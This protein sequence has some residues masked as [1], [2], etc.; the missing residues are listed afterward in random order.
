[1]IE[2][3][4]VA[5]ELDAQ[6][7][8]VLAARVNDERNGREQ[9]FAQQRAE[10]V[11]HRGGAAADERVP[12]ER[13]DGTRARRLRGGGGALPRNRVD[14][15]K[16]AR[17]CAGNAAIDCRRRCGPQGALEHDSTGASPRRAHPL[18]RDFARRRQRRGDGV[19]VVVGVGRRRRRGRRVHNQAREPGH[20]EEPVAR[21]RSEERVREHAAARA[22]EL[23]DD[24]VAVDAADD[25]D[26]P[27]DVHRVGHLVVRRPTPLALSSSS[28][29]TPRRR[30]KLPWYAEQPE[31]PRPAR[32]LRWFAEQ[33]AAEAQAA[34][35]QL[36]WFAA[37]QALPPAVGAA[38]DADDDDDDDDDE[39][40]SDSL[41]GLE[42]K[43]RAARAGATSGT[44]G[45]GARRATDQVS[46][47]AE[48]HQQATDAAESAAAAPGATFASVERAAKTARAA[49]M[50]T[51]A[52]QQV[53][54]AAAQSSSSASS[55]SSSSSSVAA[56]ATVV[57][58][59]V[60]SS[61]SVGAVFN[62]DGG[63]TPP[64]SAAENYEMLRQQIDTS[65]RQGHVPQGASRGGARVAEVASELFR[66]AR[67]TLSG[68]AKPA[69]V[70]STVSPLEHTF[71]QRV[72]TDTVAA[73]GLPPHLNDP[74]SELYA[75]LRASL[76]VS[77]RRHEEAM[78][79]P[80][81]VGE[82]ECARGASCV[83]N[84]IVSEGSGRTLV[85]FYYEDELAQYRYDLEHGVTGAR[86]PDKSRMCILC[87]RSDVNRWIMAARVQNV[88]YR[89]EN[90]LD[91][92]APVLVQQ[93]YNLVNVPGEYRIE[94]C[95]TP[96]A[97]VHEG[98]V[99]PVVKPNLLEIRRVVDPATG[100]VRFEQLLQYPSAVAPMRQQQQQQQ[101]VSAVS[102]PA[103]PPR[104][105]QRVSAV[106]AAA[107][108]SSSTTSSS[109]SSRADER[110]GF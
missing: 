36:P 106:S 99:Y 42:A 84:K 75:R 29:W 12:R 103:S 17:R 41:V 37:P 68:L 61:A 74:T 26:L 56:A 67:G 71:M 49:A 50:P 87:M 91:G 39:S 11:D 70:P 82:H 100:E 77:H 28:A 23:D 86:L 34:P 79:R 18:S 13:D 60:L 98:L 9:Q 20:H 30:R 76:R 38:A 21:G 69:I 52:R 19:V 72:V 78:M 97:T 24:L 66:T 14:G 83:G 73:V 65:Y 62:G 44:G 107:S 25:D 47:L 22:C 105:M 95:H 64:L 58:I 89:L 51:V 32:R 63:A 5:K 27:L 110:L 1:M 59:P 15:A 57:S 8:R 54:A 108:S 4:H 88:Q 96:L 31:Q 3:A 40:A 10:R 94:D 35:Q 109:S 90:G 80:A 55:S 6:C 2:R 46:R 33:Q 92:D 104:P 48:A 53:A 16:Q 101:H 93:H 7:A 43:D 81:R 45:G 85:A 102:A